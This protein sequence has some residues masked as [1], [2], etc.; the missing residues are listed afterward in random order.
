MT[1][2]MARIAAAVKAAR[3]AA[4]PAETATSDADTLLASHPS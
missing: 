4:V 3:A 1:E 2:L